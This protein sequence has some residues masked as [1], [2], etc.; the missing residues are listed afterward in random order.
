MM[1]LARY[2]AALVVVT[3]VSAMSASA[4]T[5]GVAVEDYFAFETLGEPQF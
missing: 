3:C 2:S 4:Q 1:S 5:R